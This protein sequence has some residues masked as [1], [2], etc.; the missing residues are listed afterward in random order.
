MKRYIKS[1]TATLESNYFR[2]VPK[3]ADPLEF[4]PYEL[5]IHCGSLEQAEYFKDNKYNGSCDIYEIFIHHGVTISN[6]VYDFEAWNSVEAVASILVDGFNINISK[7]EII[8]DLRSGNWSKDS[9]SQYIKT[10]VNK[11]NL[12]V[13]YNN[14]V[15]LNEKDI[16]ILDDS[17]IQ[18]IVKA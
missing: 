10:L 5:G 13:V 3:G 17:C 14:A 4:R 11:Q 15:E 7:A 16:I 9:A 1:S 2:V 18:N 6:A 8:A 12:I